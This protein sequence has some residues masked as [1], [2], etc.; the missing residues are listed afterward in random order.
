MSKKQGDSS[1]AR[2]PELEASTEKWLMDQSTCYLRFRERDCKVIT[3]LHTVKVPADSQDSTFGSKV[4]TK[5]LQ[6]RVQDRFGGQN[7]GTGRV[8]WSGVLCCASGREG[9]GAGEKWI[10]RRDLAA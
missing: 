8:V 10:S 1:V 9:N 2:P 4:E 3:G 7:S 5:A 6:R